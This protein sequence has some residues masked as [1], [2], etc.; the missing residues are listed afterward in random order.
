[1]TIHLESATTALIAGALARNADHRLEQRL[2]DVQVF[3]QKDL[4]GVQ[5]AISRALAE[6][7]EPARAA[8]EHLI[9]RGGK[10]VRPMSLLLAARCFG[11][12]SEPRFFEMSAVV[13]LAHSATLLHDDVVDEGME[14]RGAA[15]SRRIFGNGVSVLSGDM[16]LIEAL[17]RTERFAPTLLSRLIATLARLVNGEIIQLRGRTQLDLSEE[18]YEQILRDKTASLF[19][20]ASRAGAQMAGAS[21]AQQEC[22]AKYGESLGIA[23]QLVDDVIDYQGQESGKT[24]FADLIE[25]KLT[26]P[27]VLAVQKDPSLAREL[28][29]IHEGDASVVDEVSRRVV[30]S[31][32]CEEVRARALDYT[33]ASIAALD[34]IP[35]SPAKSLLAV[36]AREMTRRVS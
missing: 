7:I 10:R 1:M 11:A 23:F 8:A 4:A 34:G 3:L 25:G 32:S 19:S 5:E 24:L 17:T 15:T 2:S 9:L 22:L 33:E 13:E 20:F 18:T 29:K 16:L 31:G 12:S 27:L 28:T 30:A 14:R 26:L 6:G 36:V 35:D 21:E